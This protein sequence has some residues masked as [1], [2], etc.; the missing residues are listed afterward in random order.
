M[1]M[2]HDVTLKEEHRLWVFEN[3]VLRRLFRL[4]GNEVTGE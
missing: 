3:R 4:K 2:K 1:G